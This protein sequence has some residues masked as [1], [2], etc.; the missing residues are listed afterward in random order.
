MSNM[1]EFL[2][3]K[4]AFYESKGFSKEDV[5]NAVEIW[6]DYKEDLERIEDELIE[7]GKPVN[8]SDYELRQE[9]SW[10]W[11]SGLLDEIEEKYE[12]VR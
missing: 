6:K 9:D 12:E 5:K 3:K 1:N 4:R 10:Q 7:E 8:G 2:A 11:Y